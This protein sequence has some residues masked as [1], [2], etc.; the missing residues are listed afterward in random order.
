[1]ALY[2]KFVRRGMITNKLIYRGHEFIER[3]KK[4][5]VL[6]CE[7]NTIATQANHAF[8]ELSVKELEIIENLEF[9]TDFDLEEKVSELSEYEA[10]YEAGGG[11]SKED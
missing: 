7:E 2:R 1:M 3:W 8:E 11:S 5:V 6:M 9:Y 10:L 4:D